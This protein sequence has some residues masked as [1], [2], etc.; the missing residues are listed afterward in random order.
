VA[1]VV[2][3]APKV[4]GENAGGGESRW[5][6]ETFSEGNLGVYAFGVVGLAGCG[7]LVFDGKSRRSKEIDGNYCLTLKNYSTVFWTNIKLTRF[8]YG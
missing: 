1:E 3:G 6:A 8:W 7:K 4:C 2:F 5:G